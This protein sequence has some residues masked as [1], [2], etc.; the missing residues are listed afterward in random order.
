MRS[1]GEIIARR[2]LSVCIMFEI[3]R[4]ICC[5]TFCTRLGCARATTFRRGF[6]APA[7]RAHVNAVTVVARARR[8]VAGRDARESAVTDDKRR[9][10]EIDARARDG[11]GVEN[12]T[13]GD[14]RRRVTRVRDARE[15]RGRLAR[16]VD[17][18]RIDRARW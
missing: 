15:E 4:R 17:D 10:R 9:A 18:R 16:V 5:R 6:G 14:G 3:S 12:M 2:F 7:A 1:S 8:V 13:N 11:V